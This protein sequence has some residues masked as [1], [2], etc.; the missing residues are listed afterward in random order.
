MFFV[1]KTEET[2]RQIYMRWTTNRETLKWK[3]L[4]L[5]DRTF[6]GDDAEYSS[7]FVG[8]PG[9]DRMFCHRKHQVPCPIKKWV[10]HMLTKQTLTVNKGEISLESPLL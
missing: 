7:L 3:P 1:L 10:H 2:R 5:P 6:D 8:E 9:R 4:Y